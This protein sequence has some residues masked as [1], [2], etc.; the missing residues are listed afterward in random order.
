MTV[1]IASPGCT[2]YHDSRKYR[3]EV[4]DSRQAKLKEKYGSYHHIVEKRTGH[5]A[6]IQ[7]APEA[8]WSF[9]VNWCRRVNSE[10]SSHF[11]KTGD[12]GHLEFGSLNIPP[13]QG[14]VR[15]A[16]ADA[17]WTN[18]HDNTN[19]SHDHITM[20]ITQQYQMLFPIY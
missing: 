11:S 18:N 9:Y 20:H 19:A 3:W 14:R 16:R 15:V 5:P 6:D 17:I 4:P 10:G 13:Q 7:T 2:V 8:F 12:K 1:I